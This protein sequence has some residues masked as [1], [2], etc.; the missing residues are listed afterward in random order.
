MTHKNLRNL[1][2]A[3]GVIWALIFIGIGISHAALYNLQSSDYYVNGLPTSLTKAERAK[4]ITAPVTMTEKSCIALKCTLL[5]KAK[6]KLKIK[7]LIALE[8]IPIPAKCPDGQTGIP[9]NCITPP[10]PSLMPIVDVSKNMQPVVGWSDLRIRPNLGPQDVP[11]VGD[12][13]GQ[14]RIDCD[15]SHMSND[16]PIL[17]PR[18]KGAAHH[19]TFFG[20]T[21]LNFNSDLMNLS[22][23]GNSTCRGGIANRSAYWV[24][25]MIDTS[26]NAAIKPDSALWYYKTGYVVNKSKITSPPKGLRM[27]AGN[28][29]S[30]DASTSTRTSF[31]CWKDNFNAPPA[32]KNIPACPDGGF[33]VTHISFS[34]CWN[35][36]DLDSPNHQDHMA[37]PANFSCPA[38]HPIAIPKVDLNVWYKVPVGVD[39]KKWRLSS[40][41]YATNG[42]N[43][44]YSS[45]ADIVFG[46]NEKVMAGIVKNC[47]NAGLNAGNHK[48]CDGTV[49]Y[50]SNVDY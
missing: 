22:N 27:I 4:L 44:G 16:D 35:G 38:S 45:H 6:A 10:A 24:P 21:S 20:N 8:N 13:D 48:L 9:P 1:I 11:T 3:V 15:V 47:L 23:T 18:Q 28:M 49:I 14:F 36:K 39:T 29:K 43:G 42:L 50:G 33:L 2:I 12:G 40:D 19:H 37:D 41:N 25:S 7:E 31:S 30:T 46:W 17:Y 32:S 5:D 26:A 34:Q